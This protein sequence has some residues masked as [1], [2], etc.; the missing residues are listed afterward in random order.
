MTRR[1]RGHARAL[2]HENE[3]D[4]GDENSHEP[5]DGRHDHEP[6]AANDAARRRTGNGHLNR[7]PALTGDPALGH[8]PDLRLHQIAGGLNSVEVHVL[9]HAAPLHRKPVLDS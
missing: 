7:F 8:L 3:D 2:A 1:R 9:R 5:S 6:T 4:E